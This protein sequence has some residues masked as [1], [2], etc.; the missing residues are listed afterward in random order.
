MVGYVVNGD[1]IQYVNNL[2][3]KDTQCRLVGGETKAHAAR[4]DRED[5]PDGYY[6]ESGESRASLGPP[7]LSK[8]WERNEVVEAS[9]TRPP[10]KW[11]L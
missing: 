1:V 2:S 6:E 10:L 9:Q 3:M 5:H 4:H 11:R 7:C 8:K